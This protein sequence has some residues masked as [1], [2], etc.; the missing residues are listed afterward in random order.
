MNMNLVKH[1]TLA[2]VF[3]F[4]MESCAVKNTNTTPAKPTTKNKSTTNSPTT[5]PEKPKVIVE[6]KE[7]NFQVHSIENS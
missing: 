4:C 2:A 3:A 7:E 1:A 6:N 5:S